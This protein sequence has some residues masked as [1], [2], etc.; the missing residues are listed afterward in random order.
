[1]QKA[2]KRSPITK[3]AEPH[4]CIEIKKTSQ[5]KYALHV[6]SFYAC[7]EKKCNTNMTDHSVRTWDK[8]H[9]SEASEALMFCF[10]NASPEK[11]CFGINLGHFVSPLMCFCIPECHQKRANLPQQ[12][13]FFFQFPQL[14]LRGN[15]TDGGKE[16]MITKRTILVQAGRS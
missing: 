6:F 10:D 4:A 14:P 15:Q 7:I 5:Y 9:E 13:K 16:F 1:M 11:S 2:T 8:L 12:R 3:E